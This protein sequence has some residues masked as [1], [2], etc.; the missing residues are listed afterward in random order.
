MRKPLPTLGIEK[1]FNL[2]YKQEDFKIMHHTPINMPVIEEAHKHDFFMLLVI[3]KGHGTH[4]IDFREYKAG[5]YTVFFLAP[6]QAHQWRLS[7][8]TQG[9]QVM[10]SGDFMLHNNQLWPFFAPASIP[11]LQLNTEEHRQLT[12][13]LSLM[14]K[15]TTANIVQHR[16]QIVLLLLQHWYMNAHPVETAAASSH[17]IN[18]FLQLLEKHYAQDSEVSYYAGKL[19]VTPSYLNQVCKKETGTTA[20]EYIRERILL[21]ARRMLA[22][23]TMDVKE[24][25]WTLGF[26]DSSYFSRFFK[27]YSGQAPL[28]FR[29]QA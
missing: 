10:F 18:R 7:E 5:P 11:F 19:H 14:E 29:R 25:A 23:T 24:I 8:N 22:L 3:D 26:N 1:I 21:E 13:E 15:E 17:L 16:L 28:D 4:S 9:Y 6:G 20:G 12:I 27:K 2:P